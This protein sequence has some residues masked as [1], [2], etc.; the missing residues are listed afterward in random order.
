M[1][2]FQN[3]RNVGISGGRFFTIN[4]DYNNFSIGSGIQALSQAIS[5]GAMHDS[6]ERDPPPRCYPGTRK[7]VADDILHWLEDPETST[8][9]LW[10]IGRAGVGKSALMQTIAE[11]LFDNML[12]LGGSFFFKKRVSKC[13]EKRYL[14]PTLAYQL[15]INVAG[16]R[17]YINQ[18]MEGNPALPTKSAAI[19]L[20]HL[21]LEPFM[22]LPTPR[23]SPVII[24]DGLDECDGSDAQRDIL[25]LISQVSL[26]PEITIRF[27]IASRPE[28][29]ITHMFNKEPLK[30]ARRLVLDE[31]YESLSDIMIYLRDGFT[32]IRERTSMNLSQDP[33]PSESQ[34]EKLA[35][36]ASGQFIYASTV[37]KFVGSDFC[38]PAEH[39]DI[40]LHPG[41]MQAAAF[42]ELDHLYVQILSVHPDPSF[43]QSVL[44]VMIVFDTELTCAIPGTYPSFVADILGTGEGKVCTALRAIQS[45]TA[46]E[47][48]ATA[49]GIANTVHQIFQRVDFAHKSFTD[50]L[51]DQARSKQYFVDFD[52]VQSQVLCKAFDLVIASIRSATNPT[53]S[54]PISTWTHS[55]WKQLENMFHYG[56]MHN[57]DSSET[58]RWLRP[59]S[60]MALHRSFNELRSTLCDIP[61][62]QRGVPSPHVFPALHFAC[63]ALNVMRIRPLHPEMRD[64]MD[65]L[66]LDTRNVLDI[67]YRRFL[68]ASFLDAN[69]LVVQLALDFSL[70]TLL[71]LHASG[72]TARPID[73][74][75]N[76]W[77]IPH[78]LVQSILHENSHFIWSNFYLP[79]LESYQGHK[80]MSYFACRHLRE[81]VLDPLRAQHLHPRFWTLR[82]RKCQEAI[83]QVLES[84]NQPTAQEPNSEQFFDEDL[85][86][87]LGVTEYFEQNRGISSSSTGILDLQGVEDIAA[88][89]ALQNLLEFLSSVSWTA[90]FL[91]TEAS[92][93]ITL[94]IASWVCQCMESSAGY[95]DSTRGAIESVSRA[96]LTNGILPK[97]REQAILMESLLKNN[98]ATSLLLHDWISALKQQEVG[99]SKGG[100]SNLQLPDLEHRLLLLFTDITRELLDAVTVTQ[101]LAS[102]FGTTRLEVLL[103]QRLKR[104]LLPNAGYPMHYWGWVYA[105]LLPRPPP[106]DGSCVLTLDALF[107]LC[108]DISGT[109]S[110]SIPI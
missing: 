48:D 4:G 98:E 23:P 62:Q 49:P 88:H 84:I 37:L 105:C 70:D 13:D 63:R 65:K 2:F 91:A 52:A 32:Q 35:W 50:F 39:L 45:L 16:M 1:S 9:V 46:V 76:I 100:K 5:H 78:T 20:Q 81:F 57:V 69:S 83:F 10:V 11:L 17:E 82:I 90:V 51:M 109:T 55:T 29:Q 97:F 72:L 79:N 67:Y 75:S 107:F 31:D 77:N 101:N 22:R 24:I 44:G 18:A 106:K 28:Y 47:G 103:F 19:Q 80:T 21:I 68:G 38:D 108:L 93:M 27:I 95:S 61:L 66:F 6:S 15:A 7:K 92:T 14:F 99:I 102:S 41:P 87:A 12:E 85:R 96:I 110:T 53:E 86:L 54:I 94:V 64:T 89:G 104:L 36:R 30:M 58:F 8:S 74:M 26:I 56:A 42:S 25:T 34:L 59:A 60:R 43:L 73:N 40:I 33:W 71:P 3:A